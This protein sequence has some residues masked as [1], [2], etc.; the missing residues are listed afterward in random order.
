MGASSAAAGYRPTG[1][2]PVR[3]SRPAAAMAVETALTCGYAGSPGLLAPLCHLRAVPEYS[4]IPLFE[5]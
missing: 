5:R 2:S 4:G 1:Q 3:T